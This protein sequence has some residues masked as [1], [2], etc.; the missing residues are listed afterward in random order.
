MEI[1]DQ[2]EN[3]VKSAISTISNLQAKVK[4]LEEEKAQYQT[5]LKEMLNDL[6]L[7]DDEV[8]DTVESTTEETSD[9]NQDSEITAGG[10]SQSSY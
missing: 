5:K 2:I 4:E 6:Q 10:G 3:K 7:V 1:L 9:Q 8:F